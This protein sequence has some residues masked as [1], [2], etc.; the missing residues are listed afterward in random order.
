MSYSWLRENS[1]DAM[2]VTQGDLQKL[3]D[4]ADRLFSRVGID[5]AFTRHFLDRVNDER[6]QKQITVGE[7]IRIFKQEYKYY[8]KKI[9]QLGPDAEAVMKDMKTDV[10]IP[11]ALQ[12]DDKNNELDLIAKTVM[13]KKDFKTP[14]PEF[15]V[16][17]VQPDED[18]VGPN[19]F[20]D[21]APNSEIYVDMDGVLAD[22]FGEWA[23]LIG[24]NNWKQIQNVDAALDKVREQD[25]FWTNLPMTSNAKALLNAIKKFKGKYNI[26]S[27]PLPN[28]P[29][30]A[31]GKQEWIKKN[32][33]SFPPAK[34]I[35][36]HD[37]AK[38]A[39]QSDG[40]PNALIDDYG[41]NIKKWEAAG[42]V[43]IKHKD[44][45]VQN[46]VNQ[47][48]AEISE[49]FVDDIKR[50]LNKKLNS[51]MYKKAADAFHNWLQKEPTPHRHS[52]GFYAM[53]FARKYL[54]VDWRNLKDTYLDI[55]GD[56]AIVKEDLVEAWSKQY[57]DSIDCSNPKGFSQK[58][59]CAGKKKKE[60]IEEWQIMPQTIKPM[61]LKHKPGKG[62]NNRFDFINKSNN[63]ANQPTAENLD[64]C[65]YGKYYCSTDKK[66]KCRKGP[67]QTREEYEF[68]RETGGVGI[69]TKQNTTVDVKPGETQ[70]QAKKLGMNIDSKGNP[71][72]LHKKAAKNSDPNTLTNLGIG[73]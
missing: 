6:N 10:N 40:T 48:D 8:G 56:Q 9:A 42:G 73:S 41:E 70:R 52:L 53:D 63:R 20:E 60:D 24:V 3:E 45:T 27:A 65:K 54:K 44:A 21:L 58:A 4:Y 66:W 5:V 68:I 50:G 2:P 15:A 12:W 57:K 26:L 7:L 43:G 29:K 69:I 36:D 18:K 16:A 47:L 22:F 30:S 32:L 62:P 1:K 25:D 67:K 13:R 34:V 49:D 51:G 37:K 46:T 61:G 14:D 55:Y 39:K 72:L 59:H 38:Y 64:N 19:I 28:D 33:A 31:P 35:L 11:F 17:D 71:P 23:K